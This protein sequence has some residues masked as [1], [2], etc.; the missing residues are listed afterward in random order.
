MPVK[1]FEHSPEMKSEVIAKLSSEIDFLYNQIKRMKQMNDH[2]EEF[3]DIGNKYNIELTDESKSVRYVFHFIAIQSYEN[4]KTLKD[5]LLSGSDVDD[6]PLIKNGIITLQEGCK[7]L[8]GFHLSKK[9]GVIDDSMIRKSLLYK[10]HGKVATDNPKLYMGFEEVIDN[11]RNKL[12]NAK[13]KD[14]RCELVH[15]QNDKGDFNPFNFSETTLNMN[16]TEVYNLLFDY[17]RFLKL[18][19]SYMDGLIKMG[20][21]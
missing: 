15:Y 13:I 20:Y 5:M 8:I 1:M 4:S 3:S 11:F 19:A 14:V 12:E 2:F 21:R 17:Y 18:I 16:A 10:L 7:R 9:V 6:I